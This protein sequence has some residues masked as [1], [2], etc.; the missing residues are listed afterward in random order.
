MDE[1]I[2]NLMR[3]RGHDHLLARVD[4]PDLTDRIV[5]SLH[6][7]DEQAEEIRDAMGKVVAR[8]LRMMARMGVYFEET[9]ARRYP[10]FPIRSGVLDWED[11][12]PPLGP[13]LRALLE[14]HSGVLT[15]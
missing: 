3:E 7:L 14:N 13:S 10:D 5:S 6:S 15:A 9:V 1:R 2:R 8:N 12:L 11:Y 4:D